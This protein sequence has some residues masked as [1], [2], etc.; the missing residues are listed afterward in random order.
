MII[1]ISKNTLIIFGPEN[2][3]IFIITEISHEDMNIL[4]ILFERNLNI[5]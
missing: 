3:G 2:T 1:K 5:S 4:L